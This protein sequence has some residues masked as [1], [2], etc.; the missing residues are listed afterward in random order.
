MPNAAIGA[1]YVTAFDSALAYA[2][3]LLEDDADL[4]HGD[5]PPTAPTRPAGCLWTSSTPSTCGTS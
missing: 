5:W 2:A 1:A 3:E 4:D